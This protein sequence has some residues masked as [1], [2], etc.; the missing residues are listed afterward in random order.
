MEGHTREKGGIEGNGSLER[1][2]GVKGIHKRKRRR[3]GTLE[4][5]G[6]E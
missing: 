3:R 4:R 6:R 1:K 2:E 5:E